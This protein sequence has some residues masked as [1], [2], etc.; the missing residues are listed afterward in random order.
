ML[1]VG[2]GEALSTL[3]CSYLPTSLNGKVVGR[4]ISVLRRIEDIKGRK[5][6]VLAFINF[7]L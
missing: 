4:S 3:L 6:I 7:I 5:E 1:V 2:R